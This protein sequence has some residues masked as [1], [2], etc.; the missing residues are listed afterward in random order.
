LQN[1]PGYTLRRC[2]KAVNESN[3]KFISEQ[4]LRRFLKRVGH[5]PLKGELVAIMRRLDLDGDKR[6][7][8]A[9]FGE[10]L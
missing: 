8:F 6:I 9:E 10:A 3:N 7:S 1:V 2:F 5:T 4:S